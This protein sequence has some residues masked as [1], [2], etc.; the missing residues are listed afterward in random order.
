MYRSNACVKMPVIINTK[1]IRIKTLIT[2]PKKELI[3]KYLVLYFL[4]FFAL[5]K[6]DYPP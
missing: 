4:I 6:L 3:F 2:I 1:E 5:D